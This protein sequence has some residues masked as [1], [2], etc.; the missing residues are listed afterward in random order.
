MPG[1]PYFLLMYA[2]IIFFFYSIFTGTI[3][4]HVGDRIINAPAQ[5]EYVEVIRY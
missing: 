5:V 4:V 2:A 3:E 1:D